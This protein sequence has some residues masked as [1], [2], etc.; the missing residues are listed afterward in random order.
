MQ[1]NRP[2]RDTSSIL[3]Q[4]SQESKTC[5]FMS[6]KHF[7]GSN[8]YLYHLCRSTRWSRSILVEQSAGSRQVVE[9]SPGRC[10]SCQLWCR[11]C[12]CWCTQRSCYCIS[13][14][15]SLFQPPP[16]MLHCIVLAFGGVSWWPTVW[17]LGANNHRKVARDGQM[18]LKR[19]LA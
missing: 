17:P 19:S 15:T 9:A 4:G 14:A 18:G 13:V 3:C 1:Q 16:P 11:P 10:T 6:K 7:R 8:G 2:K 5:Q 12:W